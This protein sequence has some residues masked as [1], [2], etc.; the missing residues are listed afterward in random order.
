MT[1]KMVLFIGLNNTPKMGPGGAAGSRTYFIKRLLSIIYKHLIMLFTELLTNYIFL[2]LRLQYSYKF[3][4]LR[5]EKLIFT[6]SFY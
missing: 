2:L 5:Y 4:K 1:S 6:L 3:I